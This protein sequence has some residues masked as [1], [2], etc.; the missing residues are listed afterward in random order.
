MSKGI[1][2]AT[3]ANVLL[4]ATTLAAVGVGYFKIVKPMS[5]EVNS[6]NKNLNANVGKNEKVFKKVDTVYHAAEGNRDTSSSDKGVDLTECM[7]MK[8]F[9]DLGQEWDQK[10]DLKMK[11]AEFKERV[12]ILI[13]S[14]RHIL[15]RQDSVVAGIDKTYD[16]PIEIWSNMPGFV[17]ANDTEIKE[18]ILYLLKNNLYDMTRST[19]LHG[20]AD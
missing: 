17:P 19:F 14:V 10:M 9:P 12:S 11:N 5:N 3:I 4:T 15:F 13:D 7:F 18:G 1:V 8:K 2:A 6:L 16:N 20:Y